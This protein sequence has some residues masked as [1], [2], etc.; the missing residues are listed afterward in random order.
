MEYKLKNYDEIIDELAEILKGFAKQ[1]NEYDT[2]VYL[3]YDEETQTAELDTFVNVGGNSWLNNNHFNIYT[4]K[5]HHEN[6][7]DWFLEDGHNCF[8]DAL[9][10]DRDNF[11]KEVLEWVRNEDEDISEDYEVS[12]DDKIDYVKS[13]DDYL[14]KLYD[15]FCDY[16]ENESYK[17]EAEEIIERWQQGYIPEY[18]KIGY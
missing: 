17:Y 3:Y 5:Q 15:I 12:F 11:D 7:I 14:D 16:I 6:W 13:K 2:D 10:I 1:L 4:D 8:A 9:E 18:K